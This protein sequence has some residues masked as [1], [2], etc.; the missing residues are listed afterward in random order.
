[1]YALKEKVIFILDRV[2]YNGRELTDCGIR[3]QDGAIY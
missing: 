3:D 2:N 1:M